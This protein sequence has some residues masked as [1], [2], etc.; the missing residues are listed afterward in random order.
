MR[1]PLGP[2]LPSAFLC[3][4]EQIC[5]NEYLGEFKPEYYRRYVD[6]ITALLHSPDN[7]EK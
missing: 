6:D 2:T 7:L 4:Y 5:F 3:L 1:S